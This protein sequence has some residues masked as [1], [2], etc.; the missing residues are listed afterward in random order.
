MRLDL[1]ETNAAVVAS[2]TTQGPAAQLGITQSA[3]SR[4]VVQLKRSL[5]LALF[6]QEKSRLIPTRDSV[7]LHDQIGG[8]IETARRLKSRADEPHSGNSPERT[9]AI[10]FPASLALTLVPRIVARFLARYPR[11]RTAVHTERGSHDY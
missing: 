2:G 11:A 8:L 5:G 1:L 9:L 6:R 7:I 10:A 3:V 4:R